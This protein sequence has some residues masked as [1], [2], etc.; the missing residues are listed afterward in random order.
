MSDDDINL[1]DEQD[2]ERLRGYAQQLLAEKRQLLQQIAELEER[3]A[4]ASTADRAA[5][6]TELALAKEQLA[7]QQRR[8]F[9]RSSERRTGE[10]RAAAGGE[11]PQKGHGPTPQPDLPREEQFHD[12]DEADRT[13][14]KCGGELADWPGQ[15]EDAE[16]IDVV[17]RRYVLRVHRRRKARCRC[18][19]CI[20]TAPAPPKLLPGGRYSIDFA[21]QV[22]AD[23]YDDHQPL[24]RQ[25]EQMAAQHLIVSSQTLWDQIDRL[26]E[27]LAPSYKALLRLALSAKIVGADESRW[28]IMDRPDSSAGFV[29]IARSEYAVYYRID[30][31][32]STEAAAKLLADFRGTVVADDYEVYDALQKQQQKATGS[33][34]SLARCWSH[35]RRKFHQAKPDHP[36]AS[37]ALDLI[38]ELYAIERR[39]DEQPEELQLECRAEL[40]RTESRRVI[41]ELRAWLDACVCLP[42]SGLGKAIKYVNGCWSGLTLF[43]DNPEVPLDNNATERA[44]RGPVLGRK[45][46]YGSRSLRGTE[47]AAILYSLIETAQLYG[48]N[49]RRYLAEAA[50]RAALDP[51]AV[52][53]PTD[54]LDKTG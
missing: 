10:G 8:M 36:Q 14:P 51:D 28:P 12:L 29:W 25:V 24:T 3:L 21:V 4:R 48:V 22:A 42:T 32:R 11:Q 7:R 47:V 52:T 39:A 18:G 26:A 31:H 20:E 1:D 54:L 34:Y 46:H 49:P 30:R 19:A 38:A 33:T 2:I 50:R 17:E 44:L 27:L 53:L 6:E 37:A 41:G 16:E 15:T 40:R 45:T 35:V 9:G 23:K 43:L 13:C 5:L